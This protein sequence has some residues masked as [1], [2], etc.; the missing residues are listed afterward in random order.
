MFLKEEFTKQKAQEIFKDMLDEFYWA[1]CLDGVFDS[2]AIEPTLQ[3]LNAN[4]RK[5]LGRCRRIRDYSKESGYRFI[6]MLNPNCLNFDEDGEK[7]IKNTLAHELC[8]TL[9]GCF[10]HGTNF[11]VWASIIRREMG[12]IIDKKADEDASEYFRRYIPKYPYMLRCRECDEEFYHA[13]P[14]DPVKNP[15]RYHCNCGGKVDS[16]KLNDLT[17]GYELYRS[18]DSELD[19][20]I[21]AKCDDCGFYMPFKTR[22]RQFKYLVKALERGDRLE[23]PQC[24]EPRLYI[25]DNDRDYRDILDPYA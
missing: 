24:G 12:Y 22:N 16:Y 9:P 11:I 7:S 21:Y 3:Y 13:K 20:P 1:S 18:A 15:G 2:N 5:A 6:I 19:Y 14:S 17:D 23:C 4:N 8:H 10:N 25:V